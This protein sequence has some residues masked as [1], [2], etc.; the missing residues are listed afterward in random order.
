MFGLESEKEML[1]KEFHL[2]L[3]PFK[4]N[5]TKVNFSL[6]VEY[7]RKRFYNIEV[8]R[9]FTLYILTI[10]S[11]ED[12]PKQLQLSAIR[13]YINSL[14]KLSYGKNGF[15]YLAKLRETDK[16]SLVLKYSLDLTH[17]IFVGI[18]GTNGL[19]GYIPNFSYLY[20][21]FNCSRPLFLENTYLSWCDEKSDRFTYAIYEYIPG[22]TL[23]EHLYK[24]PPEE[25]IA[26]YLQILLALQFAQ[27]TIRFTHFDLHT[28]NIILRPLTKEY[29]I[30]YYL[31]EGKFYIKAKYVATFIDY[32]H[33]SFSYD[34]KI[35]NVPIVFKKLNME[36]VSSFPLYDAYRLLTTSYISTVNEATKDAIANILK[37]FSFDRAEKI[38]KEAHNNYSLLPEELSYMSL[39][40][41]IEFVS[42]LGNYLASDEELTTLPL[43]SCEK[44]NC[45]NFE[46]LQ[47]TLETKRLPVCSLFVLYYNLI[48]NKGNEKKIEELLS[49]YKYL[50]RDVQMYQEN[51]N[52]LK[53]TLPKV[54]LSNYPSVLYSFASYFKLYKHTKQVLEIFDYLQRQGHT[55]LPLREL[56][57]NRIYIMSYITYN[58]RVLKNACESGK[59][60]LA[61]KLYEYVI[62]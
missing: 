38:I 42:S 11:Q 22:K 61:C 24:C 21:G 8:L 26:I 45:K 48:I 39:H 36:P 12:L 51:I 15:T 47:L 35:Y 41:F 58:R 32:G 57:Q 55:S 17:E 13:Y 62:S 9:L 6:L 5:L 56:S 29:I 2:F 19:R 40:D 33:A 37:Y 60:P 50:T 4:E 18:F 27:E 31:E 28:K 23:Y 34:D 59:F 43:L 1:T 10:F 25:F 49:S 52:K 46:E 16:Y 53:D 14:R 30:P 7:V 3:T 54:E 20:S 44:E